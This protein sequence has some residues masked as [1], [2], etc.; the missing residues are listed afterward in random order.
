MFSERLQVLLSRDQRR[1]LEHG[2]VRQERSVASLIR[3]AID[4][5]YGTTSPER[6]REALERISART[7]EAV[8]PADLRELVDHS[9]DDEIGGRNAR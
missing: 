3:E 6:R 4:V 5:H 8:D 7:G 2:S 1:R 9:H